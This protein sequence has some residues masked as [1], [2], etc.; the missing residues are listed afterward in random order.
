MA[1]PFVSSA[2]RTMRPVALGAVLVAG[3]GASGPTRAND[4]GAMRPTYGL[5]GTPSLI[6]MPTADSAPDAE[7]ATTISHWA[8]TTRTTLSFQ[9]TP[10][11]SGSFRY[12][13]IEGLL[14]PGYNVDGGYN[15][16]VPLPP[17]VN[18]NTYY[19]RSFDLRYRILDETRYRPAVAIGLQDFIG[20]GLYGGEYIV[21]S[22]SLTPTL[23]VTGG[24]GWGRLGSYGA[25]GSL[26]TRPT[27][28]IGEGGIPTYDRWFRGDVA[29]F[30][31]IAWSPTDRL[32]LKAE[33]SSD[34][35]TQEV[36]SGIVERK[37]SWN[38]G[39]D[40]MLSDNLQVSLYSLYGSEVGASFTLL[41]NVR[42]S[43]VPGGAEQAPTPVRPRSMAERRD[44]GWT[45]DPSAQPDIR[46]R[47]QTGLEREGLNYEGLTLDGQSATL[48]LRNR[49]YMNEPQ[50][51]GR[52]ARVMTRILPGSVETLRIV[53]VVNG[54]AMSAVTFRRSDLEQLENAPAEALLARTSV[55][56][57]YRLAPRAESG[58]YPE[59]TWGLQPYLALSVFDPDNPVRADVGLRLQ[60]T[61]K[62]SPGIELSGAITKKLAGNLDSVIRPIPSDL[63]RVRTDY[64]EYSRQGD[65][66][67]EHLTLSAYGRPGKDMYSRVTLG[68]LEQMYAGVS[69][70]L[71]WKPVDSRLALGAE[72]NW[73]KQRDFDQQFG[74][75]DYDTVTGHLSAY[76]DFG[77][78]FHGQL[79][80]G[81]YLAG[82]YGATVA[83]DREFDNGWRVGA[84]ATFTDV[85]FDDFGEGSF[86][87]GIRLTI[88]VQSLLGTPTRNTNTITIQSLTR[89]G[90]ARLNV[91]DRL[92]GRV[93]DYH[94]PEL[95]QEW[96]RVWR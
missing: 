91:R 25:I 31:G 76:Y 43:A 21:A 78:G 32:T 10:R 55:T 42:N 48:R 14:V 64:A 41:S 9:I 44:F 50:A 83:L 7:L 67:I 80:V 95:T 96:G 61:Y 39:V 33:Y 71:L 72:L 26:G 68:Y 86:D 56:D 16:L 28:L 70:E 63:P 92:Y 34:A 5:F 93:R 59:L 24:L 18:P 3:V 37:S 62:L 23:R 29:P 74:L 38:F 65:P 94:S 73:V 90:G 36:R 4:D 11:L 58:I 88:P 82:D 75:R 81:R 89:D 52:A 47:L 53:P 49:I 69:G 77:N 57:G 27:G 2:F 20:T 45:T 84:Y 79:D 40:Y 35:Y 15:P 51:L 6:E 66:A 12:A 30:G 19:D 17:G 1:F 46:A 87:K 13:A 8:G 85:P 22:K 60:A 54:M